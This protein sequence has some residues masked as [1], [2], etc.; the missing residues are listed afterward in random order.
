MNVFTLG[1]Y[2]GSKHFRL[3]HVSKNT[4]CDA[5]VYCILERIASFLMI[6]KYSNNDQMHVFHNAFL[7]FRMVGGWLMFFHIL[8]QI[9]FC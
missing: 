5:A 1:I 8:Q 9:V 3:N 2:N 4:F 6:C 7:F